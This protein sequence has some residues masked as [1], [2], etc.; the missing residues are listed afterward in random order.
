[1]TLDRKCATK[2]CDLPGRFTDPSL[3]GEWYCEHHRK[4]QMNFNQE[5]KIKALEKERDSWRRTA[6]KLETEKLDLATELKAMAEKL[7]SIQK[8]SRPGRGN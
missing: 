1:M 8:M 4:R 2:Y 3:E 7:K 5:Q 6:E